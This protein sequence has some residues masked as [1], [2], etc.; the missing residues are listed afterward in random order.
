MIS[1]DTVKVISEG[2]VTEQKCTIRPL[3][4]TQ[5]S[6]LVTGAPSGKNGKTC[7]VI[8]RSRRSGG[9]RKFSSTNG[10]SLQ[11]LTLS[12]LGLNPAGLNS[13]RFPV[14]PK[15]IPV[16]KS[17]TCTYH[18]DRYLAAWRNPTAFLANDA[19]RPELGFGSRRPAALRWIRVGARRIIARSGLLIPDH[20]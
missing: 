9:T 16:L 19:R 5:Q 13:F 17:R 15:S 20:P 2:A 11:V 12:G 7:S 1:R 10:F 8:P 4:K 3:T 14:K 18:L 6:C